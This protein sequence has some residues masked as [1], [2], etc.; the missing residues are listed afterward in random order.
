GE[1]LSYSRIVALSHV[2]TF[3]HALDSRADVNGLDRAQVA[4]NRNAVHHVAA[5]RDT[6]ISFGERQSLRTSSGTTSSGSGRRFC[7]RFL[8]RLG[9]AA[10]R[11]TNDQYYCSR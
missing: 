8:A 9:A 6:H 2:H 1:K 4:S 3:E 5:A 10:E 7:G 11:D